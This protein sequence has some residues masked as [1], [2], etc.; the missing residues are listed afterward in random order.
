LL[1]VLCNPK[2]E[3][4]IRERVMWALRI[5]GADLPDIAGAK[6]AFTRVLK[7]PLNDQNKMLR[8][9]CAYMLGMIWQKKAPDATLDVLSDYLRDPTTKKYTGTT[10][11]VGPAP[12]EKKGGKATVQESGVGDGRV[13]A[14]DALMMMGPG[15]YAG[16]QDIMKQLRI[17]ADDPKTYEPLRKKAQEL[18]KQA[19][20]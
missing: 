19:A 2:H 12:G 6:D 18:L 15:R 16:R 8:Y 1:D 17:L 5:H 7:E 11:G 20:Q 3:V 14:C 4:K 13:L 9:D 10:V